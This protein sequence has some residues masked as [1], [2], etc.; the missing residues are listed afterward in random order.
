ME[1]VLDKLIFKNYSNLN[2]IPIAKSLTEIVKIVENF[3]K[4]DI[5][6]RDYISL[7][8]EVEDIMRIVEGIELDDKVFEIAGIPIKFQEFELLR[9]DVISWCNRVIDQQ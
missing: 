3:E 9:K 1:L 8:V 6:L 4:I 2:E 7:L 5:P